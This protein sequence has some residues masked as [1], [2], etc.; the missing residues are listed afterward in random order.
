V[1]LLGQS[2]AIF[3]DDPTALDGNEH[4]DQAI[5]VAASR[6]EQ[7]RRRDRG[8][9]ALGAFRPDLGDWRQR[10]DGVNARALNLAQA[11]QLIIA[12]AAAVG[13]FSFVRTAQDGE[14]R[15]TCSSLCEIRPQ[16]A[17]QNRIAP[18]FELERVTGGR[19]RLSDYQKRGRVVVLNFWTKTCQPCLEEMPSLAKFATTLKARQLGEFVSICTDDTREDVA[20]TLAQVLPEG[21]TFDVL[22]DPDAK[23]VADVYG[24]K[25]YPETWFI[26]D[27]G[28]IR[29]RVDGARD[30]TQPLFVDF[31]STLLSKPTCSIEFSL[32]RPRG[33]SAWLCAQSSV[34]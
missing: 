24:T 2:F 25:L 29:A 13:V 9:P 17:A 7:R 33:E 3:R 30:Y 8:P 5:F 27:S 10:D 31:V 15:R 11:G 12:V 28:L 1:P 6:S 4:E 21:V 14:L 34:P 32:G 22:L 18:D 23:V 16:Y 19:V 26:D 20:R